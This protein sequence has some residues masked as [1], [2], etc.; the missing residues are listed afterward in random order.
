VDVSLYI[1][2]QSTTASSAVVTVT[3]DSQMVG[4]TQTVA[5]SQGWVKL[6]IG[7]VTLAVASHNFVVTVQGT[8][9][10]DQE[11]DLDSIIVVAE[12]GSGCVLG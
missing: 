11:V 3:M 12:P 9:S 7:S 2:V 10:D 5:S 6:S 4:T 8:G 1:R